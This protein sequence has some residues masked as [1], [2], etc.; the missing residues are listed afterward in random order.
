MTLIQVLVAT[1]LGTLIM[2]A[3][4]LVWI[5]ASRSF[6]ALGNYTDLDSKSRYAIDC[7]LRDIRDATQIVAFQNN[8]TTNFL[9]VTN[10]QTANSGA[11]YSWDSTSRT[12]VCQ[13][14]VDGGRT[15]LTECDLWDVQLFQRTPNSS[16]TYVFYPATN[17]AGAYDTTLCKLINMTWKCSRTILGNKINT[18]NVQTAQVVLRNKQ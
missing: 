12:L 18:E 5:F 8:G 9:Q 14:P 4:I 3:V 15:Y 7:M 13:K 17:V 2:T 1:A 10:T 16:G 6:V 11:T